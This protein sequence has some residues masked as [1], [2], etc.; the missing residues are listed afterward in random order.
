MA[1]GGGVQVFD[2][3]SVK[4]LRAEKFGR[5]ATP[6]TG[7]SAYTQ[8]YSTA[9]K[10]VA[11]A[12]ATN[13]TAPAA[14][15]AHAAGAVA[16]TSNAATDLDTTAAALATLRGEVATYETAISNLIL[17]V[18]DLRQTVTAIIDDL[19]ALGLVA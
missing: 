11:N 3:I 5:A 7:G 13:P 14:Y 1:A 8:T 18:D 15:S 12:L 6:S 9:N 16:V 10:T 17:D 4:E 2:A 19:Q